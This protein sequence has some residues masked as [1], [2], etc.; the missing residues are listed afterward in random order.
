MPPS[1]QAEGFHSDQRQKKS[2]EPVALS[3]ISGP[4]NL[5]WQLL[6]LITP[7]KQAQSALPWDTGVRASSGALARPPVQGRLKSRLEPAPCLLLALGISLHKTGN[8][9]SL[10]AFE[11]GG[12]VPLG[13]V[14][15]GLVPGWL[16]FR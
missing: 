7:P 15:Q 14:S 16:A 8:P 2:A 5:G 11:G 12:Q 9:G 1:P 3:P 10:T 6:L 13:P 4:H